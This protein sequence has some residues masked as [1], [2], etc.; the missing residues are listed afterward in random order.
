MKKKIRSIGIRISLL[1]FVV[2][3]L[4]FQHMLDRMWFAILA[5]ST[6][7]KDSLPR[8]TG[9]ESIKE[10]ELA[11]H[12]LCNWSIAFTIRMASCSFC[13]SDIPAKGFTSSSCMQP[14]TG[15][16][17]NVKINQKMCTKMCFSSLTFR[18]FSH[19][20]R[21]R[22]RPNR[23]NNPDCSSRISSALEMQA[24]QPRYHIRCT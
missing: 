10:N 16:I 23:R 2:L 9:L 18:C 19:T 5:N 22:N 21:C 13:S 15:L 6:W 24:N 1:L 7:L 8:R 12:Y 20:P 17:L 4:K 3:L 14:V 11:D